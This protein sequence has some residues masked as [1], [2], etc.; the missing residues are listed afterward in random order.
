[1]LSQIEN[2]FSSAI[3]PIRHLLDDPSITEVHVNGDGEDDVWVSGKGGRRKILSDLNRKFVRAAINA[4]AAL[5]N[6]NASGSSDDAFISQK[7]ENFRVTGIL[8]PVSYKGDALAI[9]KHSVSIITL[10][11]LLAFGT[12]DQQAKDLMIEIVTSGA[13]F[14]VCGGTDSGKTTLLNAML[15]YIP[16]NERV[17]TVEDG[18]ELNI[19]AENNLRLLE[20][21]S[22]G[23]TVERLLHG[24]LRASPDRVICGEIRK[25]EEAVNFLDVLNSGHEGCCSTIHANS[26]R[27]GLLRLERLLIQAGEPSQESARIGIAS[28]IEYVIHLK[29]EKADS[30]RYL[31][32]IIKIED[33]ANGN[34]VYQ[35]IHQGIKKECKL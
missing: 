3:A 32:S 7:F 2:V 13:N 21:K 20:N 26:A 6:R 24:V 29:K 17:I 33:Y 9:R 30:R 23:I 18:I 22:D 16:S 1:M 14:I 4:I 28:L 12:I 11:D 27:R 34:Y 25:K 15:A 35:T 19:R 8:S 5:T 10:D 31:T